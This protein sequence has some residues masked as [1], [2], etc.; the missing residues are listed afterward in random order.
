[1][2]Y[3]SD[4]FQVT[5]FLGNILGKKHPYLKAIA[6]MSQDWR[7]TRGYLEVINILKKYSDKNDKMAL[8]EHQMLSMMCEIS[9]AIGQA[10]WQMD[11]IS[12]LSMKIGKDFKKYEAE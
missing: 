2:P 11:V 7:I 8:S 4:Q 6:C 12:H 3:S 9:E 1:M 10:D 5:N